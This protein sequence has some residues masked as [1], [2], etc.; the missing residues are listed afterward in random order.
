M[1]KLMPRRS[2]LQ[3]SAA[4]GMGNMVGLN[5][6]ANSQMNASQSPIPPIQVF[7]KHL[8]FL[9]Y[10]DL[11]EAVMEM[12][13]DGIDLT[14][15][16]KGHVLPEKVKD[17]LPSVVEKMT[18]V[19]L[20][21]SLMTTAIKT[22]DDPLTQPILATASKLGFQLYRLGY[23]KYDKTLSIPASLKIIIGQVIALAQLNGSLKITGAYQNHA[24]TQVG[25]SIWEI[26]QML[27]D[28]DKKHL[29]CQYDIRHATVEG[30]QSWQTGLK[31]IKPKINSI[32]LKDFRWEKTGRNWKLINTPIGE[33]MVDFLTYFKT[34]KKYQ[35]NAPISMHF[36]YD[37]GG[38]EHGD[39]KISIKQKE[40]F[41]IMKKDLN[42]IKKLWEDA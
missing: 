37:M 31:L 10:Q 40:I 11:C 5:A 18:Q 3:Q 21:P 29:G 26:W 4:I 12:G 7:S 16:P 41:T 27:E 20:K 6:F 24:G 15:R 1:R 32:V 23:Y 19:G 35:I 2:F 39:R 14:V 38:A 28:L 25:A 36:E 17:D 42:R 9:N 34:L 22:A 13:F 30:G 33:G 8:Q